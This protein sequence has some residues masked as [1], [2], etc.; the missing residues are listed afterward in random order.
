MVYVMTLGLLLLTI[1]TLWVLIQHRHNTMLTFILAPLL[2]FNAGF[3]WYVFDSTRGFPV[4]QYPAKVGRLMAGYEA[5]PYIY[6]LVQHE[7]SPRLYAIPW[8]KKSSSNLNGAMKKI[9]NGEL[10]LVGPS[11][12]DSSEGERVRY[13]KLDPT[14]VMGGKDERERPQHPE[15]IDH[16]GE[17]ASDA[18]DP[19]GK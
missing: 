17:R 2:V 5:K 3:S 18:Y 14:K 12:F 4:H 6:L 10:V 15:T 7:T 8:T 9:E 16:Q 19:P 13:K 11:P 1:I